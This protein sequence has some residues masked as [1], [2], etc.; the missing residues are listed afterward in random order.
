MRRKTRRI[1]ALALMGALGAGGL[2]ADVPKQPSLSRYKDLWEQSRFTVPPPPPVVEAGPGALEDFTLLS[3]TPLGDDYM[4]TLKNTKDSKAGRVRIFPGE[5][6]SEFKI[7]EVKQF[8]D[9]METK[10]KL[11]YKGEEGEVGYEQKHLALKKA[12]VQAP[13]NRA[14]QNNRNTRTTTAGRPA[15]PATN[16]PT[17]NR[18]QQNNADVNRVLNNPTT[19]NQQQNTNTT[20]NA[21]RP[22]VRRV[23]TPPS[24]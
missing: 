17:V 6:G 22:R 13:A 21:R 8:A 16:R 20:T 14:A 7:L 11:S 3:V 24:R 1:M 12:A 23:P 18:A 9:Y 10:V 15:A 5:E 4:V 19:A 2:A